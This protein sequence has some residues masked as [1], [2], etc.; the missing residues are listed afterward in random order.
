MSEYSGIQS[1]QNIKAG[2]INKKKRVINLRNY[3]SLVKLLHFQPCFLENCVYK[4]EKKSIK[5]QRNFCSNIFFKVFANPVSVHFK[6]W[7]SRFSY[8]LTAEWYNFLHSPGWWTSW[9]WRMFIFDNY[10]QLE[11]NAYFCSSIV[12]KIYIIKVGERT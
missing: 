7:F 12:V 1:H 10:N 11:Q 6:I 9:N 2:E 4:K 5:D 8:S 3:A